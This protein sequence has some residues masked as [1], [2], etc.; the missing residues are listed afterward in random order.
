MQDR[1][2]KPAA[3]HIAQVQA[4]SP[5][6]PVSPSKIPPLTGEI[7]GLNELSV[8]SDGRI[9]PWTERY[10][11]LYRTIRS[12]S[13]AMDAINRG[14]PG[15]MIDG[16]AEGELTFAVR[17]AEEIAEKLILRMIGYAEAP[18]AQPFPAGLEVAK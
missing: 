13:G 16:V 18:D 7:E 12:V 9:G 6:R 17:H 2:R 10:I 3:K 8:F 5:A 14:V 11:A 1:T 15:T 4:Q